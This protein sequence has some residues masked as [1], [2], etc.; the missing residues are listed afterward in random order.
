MIISTAL[1]AVK[2]ISYYFNLQRET[3]RSYGEIRS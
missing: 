1:S 3:D 2:G